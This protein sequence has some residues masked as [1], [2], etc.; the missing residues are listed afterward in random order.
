LQEFFRAVFGEMYQAEYT[1]KPRA[2]AGTAPVLGPHGNFKLV[3]CDSST[4]P[5]LC[6]TFS[7]PFRGVAPGR[8]I[9]SIGPRIF[10]TAMLKA[11]DFGALAA[12]DR[13]QWHHG[14]GEQAHASRKANA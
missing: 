2:T 6:T 14:H 11:N 12:N 7:T 8:R 3:P 13:S 4:A 9:E 5:L 10:P 1:G